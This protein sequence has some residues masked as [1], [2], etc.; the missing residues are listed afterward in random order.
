MAVKTI[1]PVTRDRKNKVLKRPIDLTGIN[2]VPTVGSCPVGKIYFLLVILSRHFTRI[3]SLNFLIWTSEAIPFNTKNIKSW[4][5]GRHVPAP[6]PPKR[7]ASD[8]CPSSWRHKLDR[9]LFNDIFNVFLSSPPPRPQS[10]GG[11]GV[12]PPTPAPIRRQQFCYKP[13]YML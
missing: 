5:E 11:T 12:S 10:S 9:I 3:L 13:V 4:G 7:Y 6:P 8:Y 1:Y 2:K